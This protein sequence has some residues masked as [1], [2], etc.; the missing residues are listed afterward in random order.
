ML[1]RGVMPS[2]ANRQMKPRTGA[3]FGQM[4][5][6]VPRRNINPAPTAVAPWQQGDVRYGKFKNTWNPWDR[7][8]VRGSGGGNITPGIS[9]NNQAFAQQPSP[10]MEQYREGTGTGK[11]GNII[12]KVKKPTY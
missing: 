8:G 11:G 12:P 10:N 2:R 7:A 1:R 4:N 6:R 3:N 9:Q 5:S